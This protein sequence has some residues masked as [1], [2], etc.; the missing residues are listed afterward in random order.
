MDSACRLG[1]CPSINLQQIVQRRAT[2]PV[3]GRGWMAHGLKRA[4][5]SGRGDKFDPRIA[6]GKKREP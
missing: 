6:F 5:V 4:S 2:P 1:V 3:I